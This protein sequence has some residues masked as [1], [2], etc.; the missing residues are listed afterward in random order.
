MLN[1]KLL[2][3]AAL[4]LGLGIGGAAS[5]GAAQETGNPANQPNSGMMSPGMMGGHGMMGE[6]NRMMEN[7]NR[8]MESM[9]Q[10]TPAQP[11]PTAPE[12]KG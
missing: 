10:H 7:C 9:R 8:M 5:T 12:Q 3:V 2:T 6:M 4:A 1:P 11:G